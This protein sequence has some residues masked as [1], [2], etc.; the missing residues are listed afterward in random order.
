MIDSKIVKI[1]N[2]SSSAEIEEI[3]D[4]CQEVLKII[5]KKH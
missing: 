3:I 1:I 2:N 4:Y 5:V